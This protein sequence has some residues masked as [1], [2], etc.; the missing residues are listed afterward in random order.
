MQIVASIG[1]MKQWSKECR[2]HDKSIGLVPTMGYLH[3][4][5][6]SLMRRARSENDYVAAT[7]FVNPTQ[8]GPSEDL[9]TYPRDPE[10]DAEKCSGE[11]VD[12]LFTPEACEI[13]GPD[14]QTYVTVEQVSRPLCGQSRP[15]HFRGVATVVLKLFNIVSPTRAYFGMK[16]YQ[17]LQVI[18]T[19]ARDLDVDVAICGCETVREPDGLAMSSRNAYLSPG[20]REQAICLYRALLR[21]KALFRAGEKISAAYLEAMLD[22]INKEPETEVDYVRLV[23]PDTLEDIELVDGPALAVLAVRIGRTRLIDNMLL[24]GAVSP[25]QRDSPDD[26]SNI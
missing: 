3:E 26:S 6:L 14:F 2:G 22:C 11:G 19:M 9:D 12:L 10:G 20:Q 17:Q 13:Y 1:Q 16:D 5:H 25:E 4:G 18:K 7:I 15:G 24:N 8:F 21:A 23:H